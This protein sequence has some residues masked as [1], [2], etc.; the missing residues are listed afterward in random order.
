MIQISLWNGHLE[1]VKA[2]T[3]VK[4]T[5]MFSILKG[6]NQL[7]KGFELSAKQT[8]IKGSSDLQWKQ[9]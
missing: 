5:D 9:I 7:Q 3:I 1:N 8:G 4:V 2:K 6:F